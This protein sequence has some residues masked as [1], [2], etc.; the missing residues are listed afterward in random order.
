MHCTALTQLGRLND[1]DSERAYRKH[2]FQQ[3]FH[4]C[5]LGRFLATT[6]VLFRIYEGIVKQWQLSL[7]LF[8]GRCLATGL[9]ATVFISDLFNTASSNSD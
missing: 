5:S 2:L 4:Y 7:C 9:Y 3:Y 6:L 1:T 8:R